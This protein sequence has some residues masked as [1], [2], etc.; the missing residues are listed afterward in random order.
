MVVLFE[1]NSTGGGE[2]GWLQRLGLGTG[3]LKGMKIG[4]KKTLGYEPVALDAMI[5]QENTFL[6]YQGHQTIENCEVTDYIVL[7]GTAWVQR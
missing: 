2:S 5:G 3:D 6:T 4:D 1:E 7:L